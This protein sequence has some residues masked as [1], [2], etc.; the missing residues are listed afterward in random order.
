MSD[1]DA[2][3]PAAS[4]HCPDEDEL[5]GKSKDELL[6]WIKKGGGKGTKGPGTKGNKGGFQGN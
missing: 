2:R 4:H 6:A 1:E 3:V 5:E